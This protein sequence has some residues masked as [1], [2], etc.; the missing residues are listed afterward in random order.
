MC[1]SCK[2]SYINAEKHSRE[3]K[4]KE[5]RS[6]NLKS[7]AKMQYGKTQN[8]ILLIMTT[9]GKKKSAVDFCFSKSFL[10]GDHMSYILSA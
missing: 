8:T 3:E 7:L 9:S 2:H 5:S 6:T 1:L 4:F 10:A